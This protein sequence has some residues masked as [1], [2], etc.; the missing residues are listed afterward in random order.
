MP[1]QTVRAIGGY[2][3][4]AL[5]LV[6]LIASIITGHPLDA[7]VW[8]AAVRVG[9]CRPLPAG[10]RVEIDGREID[11]AQVFKTSA[12]LAPVLDTDTDAR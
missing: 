2:V 5:L 6:A 8:G 7:D 12:D 3:L 11:P 10:A 9:D 1:D 4:A